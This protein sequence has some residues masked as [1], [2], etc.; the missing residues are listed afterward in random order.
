M[1]DEDE[2][3]LDDVESDW[4]SI[5]T[6]SVEVSAMFTASVSC[7]SVNGLSKRSIMKLQ[8][9]LYDCDIIILID[10][11]ATHNFICDKLAKDYNCH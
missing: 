5:G 9:K 6:E 10:P 4:S 3:V 11:G 7:N 2:D 8:G 1:H